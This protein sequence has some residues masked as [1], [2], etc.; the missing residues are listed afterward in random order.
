MM[1]GVKNFQIKNPETCHIIDTAH[2]VANFLEATLENSKRWKDFRE[3]ITQTRRKMQNS[4]ISSL[5]P[6]S[7]RTKARYMNV[8]SLIIWCADMLLLIDNP[9]LLSELEIQELKKYVGWLSS[10]REDVAYWNRIVSIG[11]VARNLV[12][13]EGIHKNIIDSFERAISSIKMG[14]RELQYADNLT[15]F[16]LEQSK[17]MKSGERFIGS[18]EVLESLFGKIKSME[19]EQTAFGFTSLVLAG[20]AHVGP[21][22]SELIKQ[23]ITSVKISDIEE[24]S[25][26]E[27]GRSI[28]SERRKMKKIIR[29]FRNKI[30]Q[31]LAGTLE[32]KVMGF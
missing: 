32:E 6:P 20:I 3:Q 25:A 29:D 7:P 21:S 22:S 1:R 14:S 27:I 26:K 8:D 24:W 4:L 11:K 2:R 16:F 12:R 5:L 10:Y 28:Q 9:S 18:T 31:E 15:M 17:G 19:C 13:E 30:A 23:A